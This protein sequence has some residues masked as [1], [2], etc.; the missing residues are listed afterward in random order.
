MVTMKR[1]KTSCGCFE[2]TKCKIENSLRNLIEN[3]VFLVT[4]PNAKG[5]ECRRERADT[6]AG[7]GA[8]AGEPCVR[9]WWTV[10]EVR[11]GSGPGDAGP[12]GADAGG[13]DGV[14]GAEA[15]AGRQA[16]PAPDVET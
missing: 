3:I 5:G 14:G 9:R 15:A 2:N 10:L 11:P 7:G 6:G 8:P 13:R 12:A 4:R 1:A 16:V